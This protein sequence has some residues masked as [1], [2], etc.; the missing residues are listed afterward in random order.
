M[1]VL[2]GT[3]LRKDQWQ[4]EEEEEHQVLLLILYLSCDAITPSVILIML[5]TVEPQSYKHVG[6]S[7]GLN[8]YANSYKCMCDLF[9]F[10]QTV[11]RY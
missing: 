9:E 7:T 1:L 3:M 2:A 10:E 11:A 4:E 6:K 5:C 8:G